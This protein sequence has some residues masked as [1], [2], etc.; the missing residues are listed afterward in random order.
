MEKKSK[1]QLSFTIVLLMLC[2]SNLTVRDPAVQAGIAELKPAEDNPVYLPYTLKAFPADE[3]AFYASWYGQNDI[4]AVD[5]N[6]EEWRRV[7]S[8]PADDRDPS[9]S[10]DGTKIAFASDRES[11]NSPGRVDGVEGSTPYEVYIM[12]ADG[13]GIFKLT[14]KPDGAGDAYPD[15]SPDGQWIAYTS[16]EL[17]PMQIFIIRTDGTGKTLVSN[18]KGYDLSPAWSPDGMK[19]AFS[20]TRNENSDIYV[21]NVDGSNE[22]RLTTAPTYEY[23]PDWSPDGKYIVFDSYR[24]DNSDLFIINADGSGERNL[25]NSST[26]E[27]YPTWSYDGQWIAYCNVVVDVSMSIEKIRPDGTGRTRLTWMPGLQCEPAYGP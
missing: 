18:G 23:D 5:E 25:T 24:G 8:D 22:V 10:P 3:I 27:F 15:W 4:Y 2:L 14:E 9:W 13:S 11:P 6:G 20:S 12:N 1:V 16:S 17:G 19:I 7:T 26:V 21:I